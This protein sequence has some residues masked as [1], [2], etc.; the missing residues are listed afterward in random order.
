M[1]YISVVS[2]SA[3]I[4]SPRRCL[5]RIENG[6]ADHVGTCDCDVVW[7]IVQYK[8][9]EASMS[10]ASVH[11]KHVSSAPSPL[12]LSIFASRLTGNTHLLRIVARESAQEYCRHGKLGQPSSYHELAIRHI[13]EMSTARV[14]VSL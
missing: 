2:S 1:I 3:S 14:Y 8:E 5:W 4:S 6:S 7:R 12:P 9:V 10:L 11:T 13:A